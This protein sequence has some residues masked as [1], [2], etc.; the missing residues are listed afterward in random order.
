MEVLMMIGSYAGEIRD[1]RPC[2]AHG[3]I[4]RGEATDPNAPIAEFH[5]GGFIPAGEPVLVGENPHG[6][7]IPKAVADKLEAAVAV[8]NKKAKR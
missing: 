3:L 2:H 1:V 7:F 8:V 6:S 5:S 4:E